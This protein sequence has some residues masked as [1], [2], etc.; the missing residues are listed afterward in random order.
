[1]TR[2]LLTLAALLVGLNAQAATITIEGPD[3]CGTTRMCADALTD[4]GQAV[5]LGAST[6]YHSITLVVDGKTYTGDWTTVTVTDGL[7]A[8]VVA[9]ADGS[10]ATVAT[11]WS[12]TIRKINSGRAHYQLTVWTLVGGTVVTP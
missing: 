1:M 5:S 8:G 10:T 6:A 4:T 3:L 12:H 9:A 2:I 7:A 11:T